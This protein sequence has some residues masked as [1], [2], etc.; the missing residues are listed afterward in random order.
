MKL[1]VGLGNPGKEYEN[2]R[3]NTGFIVLENFRKK[4]F[5]AEEW[6]FE[7]KFNAEI[8]FIKDCFKGT[9]LKKAH[10]LFLLLMRPLTFMNNSGE[11]VVKASTYYKIAPKDIVVIHDDLDIP[12]GEFRLQKGRGAAGH[13]G[14][15]S[16]IKALGTKDFWRLRVGI[17]GPLRRECND[18]AKFVL[19]SFHTPGVYN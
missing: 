1:I 11:A 5:P 16:V 17:N 2:T 9:P 12:L 8:I 10:P 13:H 14:V 15:E 7:K 18:D 19:E 3:H 6:R 4:H